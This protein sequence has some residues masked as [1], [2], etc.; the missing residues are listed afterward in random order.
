MNKIY[1]PVLVFV[2]IIFLVFLT[3]CTNRKIVTVEKNI[4]RID[5]IDHKGYLIESYYQKYSNNYPGWYH[6]NPII[7]VLDKKSLECNFT[8]SALKIIDSLKENAEIQIVTK[9]LNSNNLEQS[10]TEQ[11]EEQENQQEE[12]QEE[13]QETERRE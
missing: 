7:D 12:E 5:I 3:S 13:E 11:E 9:N 2:S 8:N 1:K 6:C 4:R 10:Q